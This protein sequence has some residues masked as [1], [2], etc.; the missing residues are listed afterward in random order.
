[1][2]PKDELTLLR[3]RMVIIDSMIE[4]LTKLKVD[5]ERELADY[6][7]RKDDLQKRLEKE[8]RHAKVS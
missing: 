6:Q 4:K 2:P 3:D 8:E 5:L 7:S 1:M